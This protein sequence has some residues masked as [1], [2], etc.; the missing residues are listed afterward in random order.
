MISSLL[1]HAVFFRNQICELHTMSF[2]NPAQVCGKIST[3]KEHSV[4][5]AVQLLVVLNAPYAKF[6]TRLFINKSAL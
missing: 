3:L 1:I 6:I 5:I 4:K 2:D